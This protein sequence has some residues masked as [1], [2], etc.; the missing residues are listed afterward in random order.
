MSLPVQTPAMGVA[1]LEANLQICQDEARK[2]LAR[3]AA[4]NPALDE[5][6]LAATNA[7]SDA[8]RFLRMSTKLALALAKLK[9]EHTNNINVRKT[10]V[11]EQELHVEFPAP[12]RRPSNA[13]PLDPVTESRINHIYN[14]WLKARVAKEGDVEPTFIRDGNGI[15][16]DEDGQEDG[17]KGDPPPNSTGSNSGK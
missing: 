15:K 10:E 2:A 13:P 5:H 8:L 1:S 17:K 11:A 3:A 16:D 12:E 6:G 4:V 9:G 14:E 7:N